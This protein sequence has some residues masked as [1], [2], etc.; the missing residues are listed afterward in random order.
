MTFS[1]SLFRGENHLGDVA[2]DDITAYPG[3]C[4]ELTCETNEFKCGSS[5]QCLSNEFLCDG[6]NDCGDFSDERDCTCSD[7]EWQCGKYLESI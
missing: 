7:T 6:T 5:L 4:G 2:I 3:S 1:Y